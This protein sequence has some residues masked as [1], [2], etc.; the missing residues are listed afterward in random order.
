MFIDTHTHLGDP[1]FDADRDEVMD[2]AEAAGVSRI[3]EVADAP[4]E[5]DRALDLCRARP[6]AVRCAL[7]LHPYHAESWT[8]SLAEELGRRARLPEVVAAGE[9]GLDYA[10]CEVPAETQ[11]AAL[12]RMLEAS[13]EAGLPVVIHCRRAHSD[14]MPILTDFFAGRRPAGR[15]HGVLHCFSGGLQEAAAAVELGFALGADG[16]VTYPKNDGLREAL[17]AAGLDSIVLETDSPWL[18]PQSLRGKRNE[19]RTVPEIA[20][21]LAE[22]FGREVEEVARVTTRNACDLFRLE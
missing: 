19:P 10:R 14:V 8:P 12:M 6:G 2:R 3:V 18:P 16:P 1:R 22:V 20:A 11:K 13:V 4:G 17:R 5:W 9:I 15:F 21:K 7:G